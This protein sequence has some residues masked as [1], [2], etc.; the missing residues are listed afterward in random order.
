M[1]S[2]RA[3][4]SS[5]ADGGFKR[6]DLRDHEQQNLLH[7]FDTWI[8]GVCN[9]VNDG[10]E[11]TVY[12]CAAV[13]AA[14]VEFL[15]AKV[16]RARKFRAFRND[17]SY[18]ANRH[19]IDVRSARAMQRRSHRG[20]IMSHAAWVESEWQTLRLLHGEGLD[21]PRPWAHSSDAI[22]ME[23]IGSAEGPGLRLVH[24]R[25]EPGEAESMWQRLL[26]NVERMLSLNLIHGD[27]SPYNVLV[28]GGAATIIDLPQVIDA[29]S[30]TDGLNFLARDIR[31]LCDYFA[32]HGL[33]LDANGLAIDLWARYMRGQL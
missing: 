12:R 16:Y 22:L 8:D 9:V 11:A 1:A 6:G 28:A 14:G 26:W 33:T 5:L 24:A 13:A 23:Y 18:F 29:R 19:V 27:L 4:V 10:K 25:L 20:R 21:V 15:A 17:V 32:G 2:K 3:R 31:N 7:S 30:A